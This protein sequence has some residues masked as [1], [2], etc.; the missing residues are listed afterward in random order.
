[1][2]Q[3]IINQANQVAGSKPYYTQ[4]AIKTMVNGDVIFNVVGDVQI[5]TL[6]SECQTVNNATASTLQYSVTNNTS[7]TSQT[8]SA[9][10][11]SLASAPAGS[12]VLIQ[13]ASLTNAP[14][15]TTASGVG[16][17]PWGAIRIAG[18]SQIKL[19]IGVG[20]TTGTWQH[21]VLYQP[22]ENGAYIY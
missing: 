14:V 5:L 4:S 15:L 21:Y 18:N 17:I 8:L 9:A 3:F 16:V 22:L 12:S 6:I 1:M 2:G 13:P 7:A 19:V 11:P 20:S 10:S